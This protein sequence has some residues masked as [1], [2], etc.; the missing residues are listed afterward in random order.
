MTNRTWNRRFE[1]FH[2]HN[3][4][5]QVLS[6]LFKCVLLCNCVSVRTGI[7]ILILT[8]PG[9]CE[10]KRLRLLRP[11]RVE[12][13]IPYPQPSSSF[14]SP[15]IVWIISFSS[16][17][18]LKSH[19]NRVEVSAIHYIT[20]QK[21]C[22]SASQGAPRCPYARLLKRRTWASLWSLDPKERPVTK[23]LQAF[24]PPDSNRSGPRAAG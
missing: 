1:H 19:L 18:D 13:P 2:H 21:N 16:R 17:P 23:I 7:P 14:P 11:S 24:C 4:F 9:G 15:A 3:T 10:R 8:L 22:P 6:F 20:L 12:L 5:F